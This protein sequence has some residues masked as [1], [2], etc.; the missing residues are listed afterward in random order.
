M[1]MNEVMGKTRKEHIRDDPGKMTLP[2]PGAAVWFR[3]RGLRYHCIRVASGCWRVPKVP[4]V[5]TREAAELE[6]PRWTHLHWRQPCP[7]IA[8]ALKVGERC[9]GTAEV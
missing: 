5:Q 3:L 2:V 1:R 9:T 6:S 4:A 8:M 7:S